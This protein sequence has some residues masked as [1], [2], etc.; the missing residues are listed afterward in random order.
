MSAST[1]TPSAE[2]KQPPN[3]LREKRWDE[4]GI[5]EKVE[6]LRSMM[7]NCLRNVGKL[8]REMRVMKIHKHL[9]EKLVAPIHEVESMCDLPYW[10][11]G[12]K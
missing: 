4:L 9:D 6:L 2:R 10:A 1:N 5:E 8:E 12:L 11:N 3:L 7:I